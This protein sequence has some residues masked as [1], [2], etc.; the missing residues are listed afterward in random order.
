MLHHDATIVVARSLNVSLLPQY[1]FIQKLKL[2]YTKIFCLISILIQYY[3]ALFSKIT[4][5]N[6]WQPLIG[7]GMKQQSNGS[8][9]GLRL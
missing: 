8:Q 9:T 2:L 7:I 3:E 4:F 1:T 6:Q 5:E